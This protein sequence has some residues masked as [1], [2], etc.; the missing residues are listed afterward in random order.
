MLTLTRRESEVIVIENEN[1]IIAIL[2]VHDIKDGAARISFDAS[3]NIDIFRE[4]IAFDR[5]YK[6]LDT[7]KDSIEETKIKKKIDRLM[8]FK[9]FRK[10]KQR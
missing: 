7:C 4:E 1:G 8:K 9:N 10:S 6:Q 2:R 5:L 3:S